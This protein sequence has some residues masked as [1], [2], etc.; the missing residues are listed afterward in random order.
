[1]LT[2]VPQKNLIVG[3]LAFYL[4][5]GCFGTQDTTSL[6]DM[7]AQQI[8]EQAQQEL[9]SGNSE[10]AA[11]TFN[12]VERLHPYSEYAKRA[13]LMSAFAFHQNKNYMLSRI[14]AQRYID[15]YPVDDNTAYAQYLIALSYYD[16]IENVGRDQFLTTEALE[17]LKAVIERYPD[18]EY[19]VSA[20]L[21]YD[22][23]FNHLAAKEMEIGRY[24]LERGNYIAAINRFKVVIEDF[25]TSS[26]IPEALHRLTEAYL[27]LGLDE[28]AQIASAILGYNFQS[29]PW[30]ADSYA[31]LNERGLDSQPTQ[32][33]QL[34]DGWLAQFYRRT[35][36]GEWL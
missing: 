7:T 15:F 14:N 19:A 13:L 36:V 23:A 10:K 32:P 5:V 27:A 12:E 18:S 21:K 30:Y 20:Q 25:D 8:Y 3:F 29:T 11:K 4:F 28:Q 35:L 33:N 26:H 16:Q 24:Y 2:M 34:G 17:S 22:L 31:L 1:M 9:N 6:E